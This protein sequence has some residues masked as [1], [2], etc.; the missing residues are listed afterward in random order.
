MY[1]QYHAYRCCMA[2]KNV[3][4][5]QVDHMNFRVEDVRPR[6]GRASSEVRRVLNKQYEG[7]FR[8]SSKKGNNIGISCIGLRHVSS[9]TSLYIAL[10]N[11]LL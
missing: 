9:H 5:P 7:L 8:K 4:L 6:S 3:D 11:S 1:R 2:R 10:V